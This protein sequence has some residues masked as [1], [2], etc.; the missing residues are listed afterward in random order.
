MS[1]EGI[2]FIR[3]DEARRLAEEEAH[4]NRELPREATEPAHVRVNKTAG[5]GIEIDWKDGH[6]SSWSFAW[7]RNACPCAT[8]LEEREA[9]GRKPGQAKPQPATVLP[10][11]KAPVQPESVAP[12]GRYAISFHWNDGHHSGIYS[13]DYLRRG[14]QCEQ[15]RETTASKRNT[16]PLPS[17]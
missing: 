5:T 2:R 17:R 16:Q 12:V 7:L 4:A 13:W 11:Y 8:C 3:D 15:C 6:R 10:M 1:H 14:C 9:S